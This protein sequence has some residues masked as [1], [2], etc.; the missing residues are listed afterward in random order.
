MRLIRRHGL[1]MLVGLLAIVPILAARGI[2]PD[3]FERLQ[4][5]V[6]DTLQ[7]VAPWRPEAGPVEV[8][9]IDDASLRHIGQWPWSR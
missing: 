2:R 6:F 5:A 3:P 9:D 8:I 1:P 7:R 4:L